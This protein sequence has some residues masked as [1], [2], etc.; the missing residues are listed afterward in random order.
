MEILANQLPLKKRYV[1]S[2]DCPFITKQIRKEHMKRTK[3]RNKYL[4]DRSDKN[5]LAFKKQRNLCVSLLKKAKKDYFGNLKSSDI[6]DNKKFWKSVKPLFNE[7]QV[8]TDKITL[9]E[10]EAIV[11]EDSRISEI[12]ADYFGNI[13]PNL[14][15][16]PYEYDSEQTNSLDPIYIIIDKYKNHPSICKIKENIPNGLSFCFQP[17]EFNAVMDEIS[18]LKVS[19]SVPVESIPSKLIK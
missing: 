19:K 3:L 8:S 4:K 2:N 14:D 6:C 17:V 18:N 16:A 11:S 5:N 7:Q 9:I 15:I 1:R 13:V 10:N 12:F